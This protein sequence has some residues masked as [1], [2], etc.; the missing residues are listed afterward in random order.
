V[1][2]QNG[3]ST[4]CLLRRCRLESSSVAKAMGFNTRAGTNGRRLSP[5]VEVATFPTIYIGLCPRWVLAGLPEN[6]LSSAV[7]SATDLR[8]GN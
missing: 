1:T 7:L 4:A 5:S 3:K 8:M 2:D 6:R